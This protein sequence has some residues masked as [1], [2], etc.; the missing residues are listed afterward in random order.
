M[1]YVT[2][3]SFDEV[4]AYDL[5]GRLRWLAKLPQYK[6]TRFVP[7]QRGPG[8]T[9]VLGEYMTARLHVLDGLLLVQVRRTG[10]SGGRSEGIVTYLL[11]AATGALK[12]FGDGAPMVGDSRG[13]VIVAFIDE[14]TPRALVFR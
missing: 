4:R 2:P 14:P 7:S 11:D 1:V 8:Y 9:M 13:R 3:V 10:A 12:A 6:G 5:S